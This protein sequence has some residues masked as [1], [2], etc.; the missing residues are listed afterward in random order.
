MIVLQHIPAV[1]SAILLAAHFLRN[2]RLTAALIC[3]IMPFLLVTATKARA[4]LYQAFLALGALV[5]MFTAAEMA[6]ERMA[7]GKPW[8][9]MAVIM[10]TV[11]L[12]NVAAAFL[13]ET[14][15]MRGRYRETIAEEEPPEG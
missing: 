6:L 5:W 14:K 9:R 15:T 13:F 2:G 11:I 10:G 7:A 3:L 8:I 12:W 4:R 1:L